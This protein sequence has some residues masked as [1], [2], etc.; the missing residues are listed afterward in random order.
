MAQT[1]V[2]R[3]PAD[4]KNEA[5]VV[6]AMQGATPGEMLALAWREYIENHRD[7]LA[8]DFEVATKMVRNGDVEGMAGFLGRDNEARAAA[9]AESARTGAD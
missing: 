6:G 4:I 1:V 9:M 2:T 8:L 3:L 5:K 7:E